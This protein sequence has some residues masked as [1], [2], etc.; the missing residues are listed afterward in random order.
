MT[1]IAICTSV[2]SILRKEVR[3]TGYITG[4]RR[5]RRRSIRQKKET[6]EVGD[7]EE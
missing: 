1:V 3:H 4:G 6:E 7:D 5:R 2:T